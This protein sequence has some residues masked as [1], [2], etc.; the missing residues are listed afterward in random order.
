MVYSNSIP[1]IP[2]YISPLHFDYIPSLIPFD[3][4]SHEDSRRPI[5]KLVKINSKWGH[6][7]PLQYIK[8][9]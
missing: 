9:N 7:L 1:I 5:A 8:I 3:G 6:V 2:W 4:H